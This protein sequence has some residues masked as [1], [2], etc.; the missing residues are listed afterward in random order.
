MLFPGMA[1]FFYEDKYGSISVFPHLFIVS[2]QFLPQ[3]LFHL[4]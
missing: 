4:F 3:N 2:F 1:L